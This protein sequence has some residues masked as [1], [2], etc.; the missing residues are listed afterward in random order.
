MNK[1][2]KNPMRHFSVSIFQIYTDVK[3]DE[4]FSKTVIPHVST[5]RK[6]YHV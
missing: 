1:I 6:T 5:S 2:T 3:I 4:S